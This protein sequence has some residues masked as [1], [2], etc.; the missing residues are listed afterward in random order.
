MKPKPK[1]PAK[2]RPTSPQHPPKAKSGQAAGGELPQAPAMKPRPKPRPPVQQAAWEE[3]SSDEED[4][5]PDGI[6]RPIGGRSYVPPGKPKPKPMPKP[7]KGPPPKHLLKEPPDATKQDMA[8][9]PD[10][11]LAKAVEGFCRSMEL[12]D[13]TKRAV[14]EAPAEVQRRLLMEDFP[15]G[16]SASAAVKFR[17]QKFKRLLKEEAPP[18]P[19]P[20]SNK[21]PEPPGPPPGKHPGPKEP[22]GPPPGP[23]PAAKPPPPP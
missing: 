22:P 21:P 19:P 23:P 9:P 7:P 5:A 13:E 3:A 2:M 11:E 6:A 10:I 15:S 1:V 16:R 20:K 18:P 12:D 17:V 14:L 8:G 4:E